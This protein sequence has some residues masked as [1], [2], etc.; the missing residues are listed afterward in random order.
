P[1]GKGNHQRMR[2]RGLCMHRVLNNYNITF[3]AV[4][5]VYSLAVLVAAA[6]GG[7]ERGKVHGLEGAVTRDEGERVAR[8]GLDC[9]L[10]QTPEAQCCGWA[11]NIVPQLEL[12]FCI[13]VLSLVTSIQTNLAVVCWNV[14]VCTCMPIFKK[15]TP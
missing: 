9:A 6:G 4:A 11:T 15:R 8:R 7:I 12:F 10:V 14:Y 13:K 1:G 3:L 5:A 2:A